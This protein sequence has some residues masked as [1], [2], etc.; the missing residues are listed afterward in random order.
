[1]IQRHNGHT[2]IVQLLEPGKLLFAAGTDDH[3]VGSVPGKIIQSGNIGVG[4][5]AG[6]RQHQTV[7]VLLSQLLHLGGKT[8]IKGGVQRGN[9]QPDAPGLK[10]NP[11]PDFRIGNIAVFLDH[12]QNPLPGFLTDVAVLVVDDARNGS[13]GYIGGFGNVFDGHVNPPDWI[14]AGGK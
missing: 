14:F 9:Q 5:A 4:A 1:M 2:L 13:W 11:L 3:T 8:H 10:E 6:Q 12:T 7:A